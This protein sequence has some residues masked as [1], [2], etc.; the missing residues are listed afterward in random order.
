MIV[1]RNV[2]QQ[3]FKTV[4]RCVSK[5][6]ALSSVGSARGAQSLKPDVLNFCFGAVSLKPY[7]RRRLGEHENVPF[8]TLRAPPLPPMCTK[9]AISPITPPRIC[10]KRHVLSTCW[11][12][13]CLKR[14]VLNI[15]RINMFLKRVVLNIPRP[16]HELQKFSFTHLLGGTCLNCVVS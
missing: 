2:R 3:M 9:H 13:E 10:L 12:A 6:W 5:R 7:V 14:H 8:E 4:M 1:V 11:G 15:M 16:R